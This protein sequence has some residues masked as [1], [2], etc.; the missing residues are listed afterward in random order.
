M[1]NK[2]AAPGIGKDSKRDRIDKANSTVFIAVAI[3]AVIIVFCVVSIRFLWMQRQYNSRVIAEKTTSRDIL[4]VNVESLENLAKQLPELNKN[5]ISNESAI[6]HALPPNYDYAGL[7]SSVNF[8]ARES[9][10]TLVGGIGEDQSPTAESTS[11]S[12]TSVDIPLA[13]TVKG[14]PNNIKKFLE[15]LER[16]TR[17]FRVTA[18]DISGSNRELTAVITATTY[19]QP[20]VDLEVPTEEIR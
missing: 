12:P 9:S 3:A 14:K 6:L 18:L 8:L 1:N 16:S 17:P 15:T 20:A 13:I 4:T 11:S 7:V 5:P 19:Y 2:S 10:V